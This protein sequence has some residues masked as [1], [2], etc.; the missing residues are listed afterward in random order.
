MNLRV[1][2]L[3]ICLDGSVDI[4]IGANV[5]KGLS[6]NLLVRLEQ[7]INRSTEGTASRSNMDGGTLLKASIRSSESAEHGKHCHEEGK[8]RGSS[9]SGNRPD[10]GGEEDVVGL[11][12]VKT[13]KVLASWKGMGNCESCWWKG[14]GETIDDNGE[15]WR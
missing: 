7:D 12:E 8:E 13:A 5:S 6:N 3:D 1:L 10:G 2:D 4:G 11:R 14:A 15:E 9:H